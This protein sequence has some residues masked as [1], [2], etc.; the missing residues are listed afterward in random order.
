MFLA[1]NPGLARGHELIAG[2]TRRSPQLGQMFGSPCLVDQL[3][4]LRLALMRRAFFVASVASRANSWESK[5]NTP[6]VIP[7]LAC[8]CG[9]TRCDHS[10]NCFVAIADAT[11]NRNTVFPQSWGQGADLRRSFF[12]I[13]GRLAHPNGSLGGVL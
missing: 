9:N 2:T 10:L 12:E 3:P 8:R 4:K 11:K 13:D 7:S 5:L 1:C 6:D